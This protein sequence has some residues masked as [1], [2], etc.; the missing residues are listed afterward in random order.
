MSEGLFAPLEGSFCLLG[1]LLIVLH[2]LLAQYFEPSIVYI[3]IFLV[4]IPL[5]AELKTS[6]SEE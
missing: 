1:E 2:W 5:S 4:V 3:S 6:Q